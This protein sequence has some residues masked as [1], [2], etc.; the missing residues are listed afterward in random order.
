MN[1]L[2]TETFKDVGVGWVTMPALGGRE[3][4]RRKPVPRTPG[5]PVTIS[6]IWKEDV[7]PSEVTASSQA[8]SCP[9]PGRLAELAEVK[10]VL[11]GIMTDLVR[12]VSPH[13][14]I[15]TSSAELEL[16]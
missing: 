3:R 2:L 14:I 10:L 4:G 15:C 7:L 9:C 13:E 1:N 6:Y 8:W 12:K 5:M 16:K 11:R